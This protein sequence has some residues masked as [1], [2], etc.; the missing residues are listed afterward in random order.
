MSSS[1]FS[2]D[3]I[4]KLLGIEAGVVGVQLVLAIAWAVAG[5]A[6]FVYS[7]VCVGKTSS[8]G[9]VIVGLLMSVFLG[10]FY[11]I[12]YFLDKGYCRGKSSSL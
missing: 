6:A 10:P 3:N 5:I 4:K 12:Y 1:S 9:K 2:L 8:A 7:V 11:W